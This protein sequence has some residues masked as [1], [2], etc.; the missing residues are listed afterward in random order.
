VTL[1]AEVLETQAGELRIRHHFRRPRAEILDAADLDAGLVDVDPVV[2]EQ[3]GLVHDQRYGEEVAIAQAL[4]N[5][6]ACWLRTDARY[7]LA[8]RRRGYDVPC[9]KRLP[10][11]V[12]GE[13]AD[14]PHAQS[15]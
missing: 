15:L 14:G 8:D 9:R 1:E 4:G 10:L 2:R 7:Q 11:A 12:G 6:L 3:I 5:R 13:H